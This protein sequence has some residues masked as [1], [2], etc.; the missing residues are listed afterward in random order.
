MSNTTNVFLEKRREKSALL[1]FKK[2]LNI[3]AHNVI[4]GKAIDDT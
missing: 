1:Y 2:H 4:D 3:C